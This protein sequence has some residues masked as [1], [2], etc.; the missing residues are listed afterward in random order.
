MLRNYVVVYSNVT[1]LSSSRTEQ[2]R[3][4]R[5]MNRRSGLSKEWLENCQE[6]LLKDSTDA[7]NV[8]DNT[9]SIPSN[10]LDCI[11]VNRLDHA[12]NHSDEKTGEFLS[13]SRDSS[14][15]TLSPPMDKH[16]FTESKDQCILGVREVKNNKT[17]SIIEEN[18]EKNLTPA[19]SKWDSKQKIDTSIYDETNERKARDFSHNIKANFI[20]QDPE[21]FSFKPNTNEINNGVCPS[22]KKASSSACIEPLQSAQNDEVSTINKIEIPTNNETNVSNEPEKLRESS[23]SLKPRLPVKRK[24]NQDDIEDKRVNGNTKKVKLTKKVAAKTKR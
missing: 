14:N 1:I 7:T 20:D 22:Q 13:L 15:S 12:P 4:R 11:P 5:S 19:C 23:S 3:R 17:I 9:N 21:G 16:S 8:P 24:R 18:L 10:Y 2:F 6:S